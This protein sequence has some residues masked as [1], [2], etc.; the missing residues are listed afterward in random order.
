MF[1]YKKDDMRVPIFSWIPQEEYHADEKMVEQCENLAKLPFAFHHVALSP[2]GHM[3]YGMPI[4]GVLATKNVIIPNAVGVDIGCGVIATNTNIVAE[5]VTDEVLKQMVDKIRSVVPV[6]FKSHS[7]PLAESNLVQLTTKEKRP[8]CYSQKESLLKQLGT[9]GGG[10]H[11]IEIQ[12][13]SYND[14][15]WVMIHSGSRNLGKQVADHYNEVAIEMNKKWASSV[16]KE[17][18]LA[19]LPM[20]SE[21]GGQYADEMSYCVN[22]ARLNRETMMKAVLSAMFE[23]L[24][25]HI[26]KNHLNSMVENSFDISHNYAGIEKH[27]GQ[28]VVVHRK[29]ATSAFNGQVGIIP[30]SQGTKSYIVE[31]LGNNFSFNSC[32]HGAGRT[33]GRNVARKTLNLDE[34]LKKMNDAGVLHNITSAKDLDEAPGAYKDIDTVMERQNDLVKITAEMTPLAVIK[35]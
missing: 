32:S 19:F 29:G 23:T 12:R 27:Y 31:G 1:T 30:G 17:W 8:V 25:L 2:D 10:N 7:E 3:G 9:L 11:F 16:P 18:D 15:L 28:D 34:E 20:D 13:S 24:G 33:M 21:E 6:G 4:G 22:Y 5:T 35:G 14:R 26:E